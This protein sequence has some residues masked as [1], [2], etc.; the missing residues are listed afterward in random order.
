MSTIYLR[1]LLTLTVVDNFAIVVVKSSLSKLE[2]T[3]ELPNSLKKFKVISFGES[4][5]FMF[6][7]FH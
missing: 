5:K 4:V 2:V 7:I 3:L 6:F 1:Y